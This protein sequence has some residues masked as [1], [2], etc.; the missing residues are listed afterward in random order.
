VPAYNEVA[1]IAATIG[2]MCAYF[3]AKPFAYEIVVAA[4]GADGTREVVGELATRNPRVRVIGSNGR[5]G[6]GRGVR[7]GVALARGDI[8]GFVDADNKTPIT[9][10]E[11]FEGP[12]ADGADLVIGSRAIDASLIERAQAPYRRIGSLVFG[13][14][15]HALV[16]LTDIADTQCGFKFFR[17][18]VA[19]DLFARQRIDGYMFDVEILA[20]ATRTGYRLVQIPVRWRD[21]ADSRLD[22]VLGNLKNARDILRIAAARLA[23]ARRMP[24]RPIADLHARTPGVRR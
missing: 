24:A 11:K 14:C 12:L 17:G 22:L 16:G 4:D 18:E 8:I 10:F 7:E 2:E 6:K 13:V 3:E 9:E 20:L 5:R 15:M 21:D 1:G 19:R 23:P